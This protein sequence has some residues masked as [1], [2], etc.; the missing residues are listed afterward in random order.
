MLVVKILICASSI[1]GREAPSLFESPITKNFMLWKK[2]NKDRNRLQTHAIIYIY[3]AIIY[4]KTPNLNGNL[5]SLWFFKRYS[6]NSILFP[7]C[8]SATVSPPSPFLIG[9]VIVSPNRFTSL[10][11]ILVALSSWNISNSQLLELESFKL[12]L[13]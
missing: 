1:R 13:E 5:P 9:I 10:W 4:P 3:R 2:D 12:A 6:R 11:L 7:C 8:N